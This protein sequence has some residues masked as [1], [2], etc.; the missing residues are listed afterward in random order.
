MSDLKLEAN[1]AAWLLGARAKNQQL[2]LRLYKFGKE[3]KDK[4]EHDQDRQELF[5]FLV[6]A[7]YSLWRAAFLSDTTR[8]WET[9]FKDS[10]TLL[11]ALIE[12]N[13]VAYSKE[14]QTREWMGGYYINNAMFRLR[15]VRAN[16]KHLAPETDKHPA[17]VALDQL[18]KPGIQLKAKSTEMCD[19]LNEAIDVMA[20]WL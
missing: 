13:S 15:W 17:L 1:H 19:V 8:T 9:T 7:A 3:N 18:S 20:M 16:L 6:G 10:M 5:A 14:R 2:L 4:L 11:E 12:D